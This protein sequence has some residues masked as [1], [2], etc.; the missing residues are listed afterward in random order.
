MWCFFAL[1]ASLTNAVYYLFNQNS[2]LRPSLFMV[3]RG[4]FLAIAATPFALFYLHIFPWQFYFIAL[5]Q[6]FMISY[7]DFRYFQ[8][9]QKFGA[10]NVTSISPLTVI[11]MF[12]IWFL[13][14]PDII[15]SYLSTPMR[16]ALIIASIVVIVISVMKYR[17]Q[18]IGLEC[19]RF[20]MPVLFVC[21]LIN[22]SNKIIMQ[23]ADQHLLTAT[24]TRVALT[25][26]VIGVINL[27]IGLRRD[28]K[29]KEIMALD[30]LKR[31]VYILLLALSMICLNFSMHYTENPAYTSAIIYLSVVWIILINKVRSFGGYKQPYQKLK[32]RWIFALLIATSVLSVVTCM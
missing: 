13:F 1:L 17:A 31:G 22:I 30:S 23:Y 27:F 5:L 4:F 12:F 28:L 7:S 32:K 25:G 11:I 14:K 9:F 6:G 16:S 19:C 20:L 10:E 8:A 2:R 24:I 15:F 18:A 29:A 26:F 3:Y 21:A